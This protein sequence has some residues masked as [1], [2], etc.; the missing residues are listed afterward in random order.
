MG[1]Q[2]HSVV[3]V[4]WSHVRMLATVVDV[5]FV[6]YA[7]DQVMAP[8]EDNECFTSDCYATCGDIHRPEGIDSNKKDVIIR[9]FHIKLSDIPARISTSAH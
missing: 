9:E 2:L 8:Y 1:L 7:S 5:R 3:L 6:L 4:H